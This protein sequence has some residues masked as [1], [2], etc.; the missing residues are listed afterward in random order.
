MCS[1]IAEWKR[2][3]SRERVPLPPQFQSKWC[4]LIFKDSPVNACLLLA[5]FRHFQAKPTVFC[6]SSTHN[7]EAYLP[8]VCSLFKGNSHLYQVWPIIRSEGQESLNDLQEKKQKQKPKALFYL[9]YFSILKPCFSRQ[10]DR[11]ILRKGR[12]EKSVSSWFLKKLQPGSYENMDRI[13]EAKDQ[14]S[15]DLLQ[16]RW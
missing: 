9:F 5:S 12:L 15:S 7:P 1:G 13:E 14:K 16:P 11:R 8:K 2:K 3:G 10:R 6:L 4:I